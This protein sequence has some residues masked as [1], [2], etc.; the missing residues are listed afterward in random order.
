MREAEHLSSWGI[1]CFLSHRSRLPELAAAYRLPAI[2]TF[3]VFVEAGGLMSYEV[4]LP[5]IWRTRHVR[6]QDSQGRMA[7]DLPVEQPIKFG[8]VIN[9]KAMRLWAC[10][11][12]PSSSRQ[13][14]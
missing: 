12:P 9:L 3:R 14:R 10:D 1:R 4:S 2:Y 6:R 5:A 7:A 8:L 13:T 11:S